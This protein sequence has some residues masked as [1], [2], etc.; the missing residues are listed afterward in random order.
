MQGN[1]PIKYFI[2]VSESI[3]LVQKI[4]QEIKR[5]AAATTAVISN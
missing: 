1:F 5:E 3:L 4:K 2:K